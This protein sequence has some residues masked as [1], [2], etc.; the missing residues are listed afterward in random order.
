MPLITLD[1]YIGKMVR[2]YIDKHY[3]EDYV[4]MKIWQPNAFH[5]VTQRQLKVKI[6]RQ[7]E[8]DAI[9]VKLLLCDLV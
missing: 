5:K 4:I 9:T 8:E 7:G 1:S 3:S 2:S 6:T